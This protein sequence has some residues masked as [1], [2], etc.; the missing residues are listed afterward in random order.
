[1]FKE[2]KG[3]VSV[4]VGSIVASLAGGVWLFSNF[5]YGYRLRSSANSGSLHS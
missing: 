1:M 5:L 4:A 2:R 3:G